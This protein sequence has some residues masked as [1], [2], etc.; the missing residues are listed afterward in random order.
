MFEIIWPERRWV[1]AEQ[2]ENWYLDAVANGETLMQDGITSE[3][4]AKELHYIGHITLGVG[5][6]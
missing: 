5:R 3:G 2:I 1:S 6:K 4:M